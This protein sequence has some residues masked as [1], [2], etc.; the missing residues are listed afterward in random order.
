MPVAAYFAIEQAVGEPL[1]DLEMLIGGV[2]EPQINIIIKERRAA[3]LCLTPQ[4]IKDREARCERRRGHKD[5]RA[6]VKIARILTFWRALRLSL[7]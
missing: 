6:L 3:C 1:P 4:R 7:F 2:V 5:Q